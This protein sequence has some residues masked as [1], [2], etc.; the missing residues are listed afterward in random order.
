[1]FDYYL[2]LFSPWMTPWEQGEL[3]H[4]NPPVPRHVG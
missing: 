4:Y 2:M 3:T 1:M